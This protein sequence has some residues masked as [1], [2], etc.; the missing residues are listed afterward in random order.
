MDIVENENSFFYPIKRLNIGTAP[1]SGTH[2]FTHV[3][4]G[5]RVAT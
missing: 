5:V 2:E 1:P 4:S 3:F